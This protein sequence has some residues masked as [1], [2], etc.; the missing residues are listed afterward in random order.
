VNIIYT[1]EDMVAEDDKVV[2]RWTAQATHTGEF[3]GV[4]PTGKPVTFSGIEMIR[5]VKG[6]AVEEWE[7]I[8]LLGLM[9]QLQ[10]E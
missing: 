4:P 5:T 6:Q 8:N 9:T 3:L 10:G 2:A 1:V 7:E